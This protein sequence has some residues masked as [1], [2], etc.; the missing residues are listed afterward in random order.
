[1]ISLIGLDLSW[2]RDPDKRLP[3]A[4]P[5]E[6]VDHSNRAENVATP[7]FMPDIGEFVCQAARSP[8]LISSRGNLREFE[9]RHGIERVGTD[10]PVGHA[11]ETSKREHAALQELAG[12]HRGDSGWM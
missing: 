3:P 7:H 2:M 8:A 11:V 6:R 10:I 12:K 1:M 4:P 5:R 9:R